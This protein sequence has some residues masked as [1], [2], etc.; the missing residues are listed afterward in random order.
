[1]IPA[2]YLFKDAYDRAWRDK[3][4]PVHRSAKRLFGMFRWAAGL[5]G[6]RRRPASS[7][8]RRMPAE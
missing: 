8:R 1:M 3:H 5:F 6:G 2:S 4:R 7:L